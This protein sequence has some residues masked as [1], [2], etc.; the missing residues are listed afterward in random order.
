[1][2]RKIRLLQ[3]FPPAFIIA[4]VSVT[5]LA[6]ASAWLEYNF[7]QIDS[8]P[9]REAKPPTAAFL[10]PYQLV[11]FLP[12]L[13]LLAFYP[14][15]GQTITKTRPTMNLKRPIALGLGAILLGLI[16]QDLF[17]F[18][19]RTLAPYATDPLAHQWIR[20][21][22]YSATFL[23]YAQIAGVIVPLWYIAFLPLII[24]AIVSLIVSPSQT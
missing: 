13:L 20:P 23:G 8:L 24:A 15:I 21:T 9:Y 7:I 17:W 6:V 18:L 1:M 4:L 14:V 22:D 12:F 2:S 16:L 3:N 10:Y 19:F 11:V 5:L